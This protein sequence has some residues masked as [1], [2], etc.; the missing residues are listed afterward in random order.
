VSLEQAQ[1]Y[2]R[3]LT[4]RVH[5][6]P[7]GGPFARQNGW[8]MNAIPYVDFALRDLKTPMFVLMGAVGFVLLIACSNVAGLMLARVSV[9]KREFAVQTALGATRRRLSQQTLTE[10][11]LLVAGGSLLGI[12][13]AYGGIQA[14]LLLAPA[15]ITEGLSIPIDTT[16][17]AFTTIIG[18]TSGLLF[19]LAPTL[20]VSRTNSDEALK[21]GARAATAGRIP[22]RLRSVLVLLEIALAFVLMVGASLFVRSFTR[23]MD[24]NIGFEPQG[25]LTGIAR[26]P[27]TAY[28][29]PEKQIAFYRAA[30][31][32]LGNIPGVS[33]AAAVIPMPFNGEAGGAFE[34]EGVVRSPSE[35]IPQGS[36]LWVSPAFFSTLQIPI[37]SGRTFTDQDIA[38]SEPVVVI[39]EKVAQQ[40]WPNQ[41]PVGTRI[42][43]TMAN[44]PWARIVGIVGHIKKMDLATDSARGVYYIPMYQQ[45]Q[46]FPA[47]GFVVKTPSDPALLSNAMREA[48]RFVDP[49]QP[50][51]DVQTMED[52]VMASLGSRR[53]AVILLS[54]FAGIALFMS[55]LG[56]YGVVSYTASQRRHEMGIRMALGADRQQILALVLGHGMR[57]TCIGLFLGALGSLA[58]ARPISRQ[59]FHTSTLDPLTFVLMTL[60]LLAVG[61]L[62]TIIPARRITKMDALQA[63]RHE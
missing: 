29:E 59:L 57:L 14:L 16:V 60:M 35:P 26:L 50:I 12:A 7:R 4:E 28:K 10:A 32:R 8:S 11:G 58:L 43:L 30:V 21:E 45:P 56:L 22:V 33:S 48:V 20:Q 31:E 61:L 34:I 17:L 18:T 54:F 23:L 25:I 62:A 40:Y 15:E 19:G 53:F 49:A 41:N 46:P 38:G 55:A 39:D 52:L 6:S 27:E 47:T 9:Q 2:V 37:R 13:L 44:A 63:C 5:E 1:A 3:I 24:V 42:R 51:G 36:R